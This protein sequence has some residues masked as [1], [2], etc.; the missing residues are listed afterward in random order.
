M[1]PS[2][3]SL[4]LFGVG[5]TLVLLILLR[6]AQRLFARSLAAD[7]TQGNGAKSLLQ[8]GQ[9][10]AVFLVATA[11]VK[12]VVRGVDLRHD[13]LWVS[14]FGVA[15][16]ALVMLTGHL[17]VRLL[18]R[19][20]LPA[21][22]ERGNV[23]AGLSAGAHYVATGIITARALGGN[24]LRELGLSVAFFVLAELTLLVF[25]TLFRALT[26]YDDAEQIQGENLAAALSYAGVS[27]AIAVIVARALEGDFE[28]WAASLRSYGFVL[29]SLLTLYP[30]RQI[31][32]Q[33]VL[34]G[35]PFTLRGGR[36]DEG[37]AQKRDVS[38]AA[39]EAV[40]YLAVALA[41]AQ[42]L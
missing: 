31:L 21:E 37:V 17:G 1:E 39:L 28:G 20:R 11:A 15:G 7:L 2:T 36:L 33:V 14:I 30:A 8:V 38:L 23:A 34:L 13:L 22:V 35:A 24:N 9:V 25:V 10:L 18:L 16:L 3:L 42:I 19:A 26:T 12:G 29:L 6:V 5:T 41:V 40:S 32:V 27:I 4:S